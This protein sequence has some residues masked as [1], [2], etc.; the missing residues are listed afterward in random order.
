MKTLRMLAVI[1]RGLSMRFLFLYFFVFLLVFPT[2]AGM[3]TQ[4]MLAVTARGLSGEHTHTQCTHTHAYSCV[5]TAKKK[6]HAHTHPPVSVQ[7]NVQKFHFVSI[8]RLKLRTVK[9]LSAASTLL[10][11][12]LSHSLILSHTDRQTHAG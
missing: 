11:L 5:Q 2:I 1:A 6:I 9:I 12:S 10:T 4:K 7:N 8:C 3:K